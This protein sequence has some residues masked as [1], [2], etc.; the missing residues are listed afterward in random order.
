MIYLQDLP[1][2]SRMVT[3]A[4][5]GIRMTEGSD[6]LSIAKNSSVGSKI[7]SFTIPTVTGSLFVVSS[8]T[9][10]TGAGKFTKS[11]PAARNL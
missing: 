4:C 8:N 7:R 10:G 6:V 9:S 1:S 5:C 3:V 2:S 11:L